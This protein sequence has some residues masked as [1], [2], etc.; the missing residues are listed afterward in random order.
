MNV[1][2]RNN[3][4]CPVEGTR[5]SSLSTNIGQS[6]DLSNVLYTPSIKKNLLSVA[7][8][9][10]YDFELRFKFREEIIDADG[11]IVGKG[12]RRN[13]LY[14]FTTIVTTSKEWSSRL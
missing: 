3:L 6:R 11:K 10:D 5:T 7:M 13:N 1:I 14:E 8:I 4:K 12:A 9:T 2:V